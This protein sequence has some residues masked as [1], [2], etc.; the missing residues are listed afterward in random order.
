MLKYNNKNYCDIINKLLL[1]TSN[2]NEPVLYQN[3]F[4]DE[5]INVEA[6]KSAINAAISC[7]AKENFRVWIN[8]YEQ[9]RGTN[10]T[11]TPIFDDE[12]LE[13]WCQR[14][15][16]NEKFCVVFSQAEQF[17]DAITTNVGM[18]LQPLFDR[19]GMTLGGCSLSFFLG[20]YGFTPAGVH[21][22][23]DENC[24]FQF[25]LGP[26]HK[27]M[28][29]WDPEEF[30]K[31]TGSKDAYFEPEKILSH[32][33]VFALNPYDFLSLPPKYY[34]I[35]KTDQFS[36]GLSVVL[37]DITN[38][39]LT[40]TIF[41][42]LTS[43]GLARKNQFYTLDRV[44]MNKDIPTL[45][46]DTFNHVCLSDK[47]K[48]LPFESIIKSQIEDLYLSMLSNLGWSFPPLLDSKTP[49]ELTGKKVRIK[50]PFKIHYKHAEEDSMAIFLRGRELIAKYNQMIILLIDELNTSLPLETDELIVKFAKNDFD[51][52][53]ILSFLSK[54]IEHKAVI[55]A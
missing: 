55:C 7:H 52:R 36:L 3:F 12:S 10:I 47:S 6:V 35:G 11:D 32:A 40:Q 24:I 28:M 1:D 18:F 46:S 45:V 22:D 38:I 27:E 34:H 25:H 15:F 31:I 42:N 37:S 39:K 51:K 49:E 33:K 17:N 20:N 26:G 53:L 30:E 43:E 19:L 13:Q 14:V 48:I 4:D 5:F 29:I 41:E 9:Y 44:K 50:H 23:Q 16:K 8:R 2:L 21:Q 54:T